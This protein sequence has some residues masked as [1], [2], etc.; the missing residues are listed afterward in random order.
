V[1]TYTLTLAT[2]EVF[3][4][5]RKRQLRNWKSLLMLEAPYGTDYAGATFGRKRQ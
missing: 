5:T 1:V 3:T 2:G 4:L